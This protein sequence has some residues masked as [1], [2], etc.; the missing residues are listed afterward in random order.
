MIYTL[1]FQ[2]SID[3]VVYTEQM[4]LGKM[5]RSNRECIVFGGKGLNVSQVLNNLGIHSRAL[6]FVAGFTGERI[7]H[8]MKECGCDTDFVRLAEGTSRI[9]VKIKSTENDIIMSETEVNGLGP[10]IQHE[11][12][13]EMLCKL[14]ILH[15]TDLMILA[16]TVP[17]SLAF[18]E[19]QDILQK[20]HE[21]GAKL[22]VDTTGEHLLEALQYNPLL[23][24]PN[25]DELGDIF[26]TR[27]CSKEDAVLY[28]G[29]L[30]EK[31]AQN[32]LI[33][34]AGD[35]AVL[36]TKQGDVLQRDAYQGTVVNS[37]GAGDAMVAGFV[38]GYLQ[39]INDRLNI[40]MDQ[41]NYEN[42]LDMAVA[43]GS[44]TAF[45]EGLAPGEVIK[46]MLRRE[47]R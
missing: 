31:G 22:I 10:I 8:G 43:A 16:G 46:S 42:I 6:G 12:I 4:K 5:N 37:V 19:Y 23:I 29:K 38:A 33:S 36:V 17:Q 13:D 30:Q 40:Q 41:K 25:Q 9:N 39:E 11:A 34:F 32:V 24:K 27:I 15:D 21:S 47:G 20:I 45:S 14:D 28:A 35:G 26:Q 44:A 3:Y 1:T 7:E 18:S 2:P